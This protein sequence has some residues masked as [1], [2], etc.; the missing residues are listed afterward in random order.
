MTS[1]GAEPHDSYNHADSD[2][3]YQKLHN[4]QIFNFDSAGLSRLYSLDTVYT[5]LSS[6]LEQLSHWLNSNFAASVF[7]R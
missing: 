2:W 6:Q 4:E 7:V 5:D 3:K 1:L